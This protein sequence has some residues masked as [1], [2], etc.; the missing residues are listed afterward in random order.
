[1]NPQMFNSF[2]D[3]TKSA[4]EWPRSPACDLAVPEDGLSFP[5]AASITCRRFCGRARAGGHLAQEGMVEV[6]SSLE[7]DGRPVVPRPPLGASMVFFKAPNDYA[8]GCFR[9][10]GLI[11]DPSGRYAAMYKPFHLI[12]LELSISVLHAV[13]TATDRRHPRLARRRGRVAKRALHA[14]ENA[15]R[16]RRATRFTASSSGCPQPAGRGA[17]VSA[18]RMA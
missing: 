8:A 5:P 3:G 17:A 10:Y 2:L 7:R 13:L 6:V 4:L 18:W 15:R 11:T 12:G 16:R 1:M 14:G 9:Q